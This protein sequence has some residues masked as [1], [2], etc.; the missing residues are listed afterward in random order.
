MS[1]AQRRAR[2]AARRELREARL[3]AERKGVDIVSA[4]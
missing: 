2:K 4:M 1:K 3:E